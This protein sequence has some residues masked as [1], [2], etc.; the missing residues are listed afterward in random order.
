MI[1]R[2]VRFQRIRSGFSL[3]EM[4]LASAPG[5]ML[6]AALY[7]FLE[8]QYITAQVGRD[9]GRRRA[10]PSFIMTRISQDILSNLGAVDP[11]VLPESGTTTNTAAP[12]STDTTNSTSTTTS[13][14]TTTDST[15]TSSAMATDSTTSPI[16]FNLQVS[17]SAD[18]LILSST[19]L[20]TELLS[21]RTAT[22]NSTNSARS[23]LRRI[24]YW[25]VPEQGLARFE[26]GSAT[27]DEA[28]YNPSEIPNPEQYI[29]ASEV[30]SLTFEYFD[31]SGWQSSWERTAVSE[32][33]DTPI[34]PPS[35]IAINRP[36]KSVCSARAITWYLRRG[37]FATSSQFPPGTISRVLSEVRSCDFL[38]YLKWST[39][40]PWCCFQCSWSW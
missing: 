39:G 1:R 32:D 18:R 8:T 2:P 33:G 13:D 30:K 38:S 10:R 36:S 14:S 28:S 31:G 7:M 25:V 19:R 34:G 17:G 26:V 16:V 20:P 6:L 4:V 40:E 35:A 29:I 24:S 23:D 3:L 9:V 12:T 5:L 27:A 11:R 22:A 15:T 21:P 37:R